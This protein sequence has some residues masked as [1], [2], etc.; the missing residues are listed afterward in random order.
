MKR[1]PAD[2]C[3]P[4]A[5]WNSG[6]TLLEREM[7]FATRIAERTVGFI[8]CGIFAGVTDSAIRAERVRS[9]ILQYRLADLQLFATKP[10]TFGTVFERL[11]GN[12][13]LRT[14]AAA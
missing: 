10:D 2:I 3:T 7:W 13:L 14:G 1:A 4:P 9:L 6:T 5:F 8:G 12:A 11:Y